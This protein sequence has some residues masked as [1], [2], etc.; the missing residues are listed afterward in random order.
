[1]SAMLPIGQF[2]EKSRLRRQERIFPAEML[3]KP[4]SAREYTWWKQKRRHPGQRERAASSLRIRLARQM[5]AESVLL[6]T[7]KRFRPSANPAVGAK[8]VRQLAA[9]VAAGRALCLLALLAASGCRTC[10]PKPPNFGASCA[11]DSQCTPPLRCFDPL[12]DPSEPH[13][14]DRYCTRPCR[15][16]TECNEGDCID[17][18]CGRRNEEDIKVLVLFI[19]QRPAPFE[20]APWLDLGAGLRLGPGQHHF[21]ASFGLGVESTFRL[22]AEPK[23][24]G[25]DGMCAPWRLRLGP[26]I[27]FDSPVDRARIEGGAALNLGG[28]RAR[29]WSTFG[30][31][32]GVGHGLTEATDVVGQISWGT[33]LVA[34][35]K[36]NLDPGGPCRAVIAP[37]SG[38][39]VF[40]AARRDISVD[41]RL[42]LTL[43]IEWQPLGHGL[44]MVPR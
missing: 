27:G 25:L 10:P 9:D 35:R 22:A 24:C 36:S 20:V 1:M 12:Y 26:W 11:L 5:I 38:L 39:R 43:G 32:A 18:W 7:P 15:S 13:T 21:G 8:V 17:N 44:G 6:I 23:D 40:L 16:R 31:R 28:P 33:R 19:E 30:L 34:M 4:T 42:E 14:A 29:S 37:A 2:Q 3:P 41:R